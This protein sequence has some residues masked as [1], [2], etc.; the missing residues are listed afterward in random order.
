MAAGY[1]WSWSDATPGNPLVD[2]IV[3]GDLRRPWTVKDTRAVNGFP[4]SP[5]WALDPAG[6]GHVGDIYTAQGFENDHDGV[7][8]D[9]DLLW[10]DGH[11]I[12]QPPATMPSALS[13][14]STQT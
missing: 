6:T 7:I 11:W 9:P 10:R 14:P 1:C 8:I 13:Q 4:L 5:R 3:I 2:D 12:T